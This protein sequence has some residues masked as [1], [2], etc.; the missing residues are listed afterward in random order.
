[1]LRVLVADDNPTIRLGLRALLDGFDDLRVVGEAVNGREA[2]D[3]A[4]ALR[5]EVVLLDVRMPV[6][7]GVAAAVEIARDRAVLMLTYADDAQVV[8]AAIRAGASGY[9]VHGT[10]D[11]EELA[12]AIRE[13]A[14]GGIVLAPAI[15]PAIVDALRRTGDRQESMPVLTEREFEV[16][17][18]VVKGATNTSIAR[19]MSISEKTVKNHI[20]HIYGKL[21]VAGRSEAIALWLG[22]G[23]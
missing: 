6:V 13:V 9:L 20:N 16:M 18:L 2:V 5:P 22:I 1:V 3:L 10:F 8:A 14:R 11:P 23:K 19:T 7:D 15:A 17:D 4:A 12:E 21:G